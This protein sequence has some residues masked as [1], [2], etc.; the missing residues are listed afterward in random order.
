MGIGFEELKKRRK[1]MNIF[2]IDF[3]EEK[4]IEDVKKKQRLSLPDFVFNEFK[5]KQY[6]I[7]G[8]SGVQIC[9]WT[10]KAIRNKGVCY[11]Q[12]F[13]GIDCH[14]C[15]QMSPAIAWCQENCIYCWRP[16]EFMK[17]TSFGKKEVDPPENIIRA[18]IPLRRQLLSGFKGNEKIN[19]T[20]FKEAYEKFPS[21]WAISL[22]GEPTLYP[23]LP[24]MIKTLKKHPE[25]KSVFLVTNGQ[26][27]KMLEKLWKE[28]ALPTQ[29]YLSFEASNKK[30]FETINKPVYKDAWKRILKSLELV[31][32]LPCRRVIRY[33]LISGINDKFVGETAKLLRKTRADF[34]EVKAYMFLGF[35]RKRLMKENMPTYREVL[36]FSKKLEKA[37]P[38]YRIIDKQRDSRIVLLRYDRSRYENIIK[39]KKQGKT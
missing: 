32:R 38:E 22:S 31:K 8:H 39:G 21:H 19:K 28:N 2:E 20:L 29:L 10:K 34:I 12:R 26:E 35:S 13:Y 30:L 6:G 33:T 15:M 11:K 18:L 36:G 23:Y 16:M 14:R 25:V 1:K 17:K 24:E 27:P 9:E 4:R 5:K 7:Y 3:P 37:M